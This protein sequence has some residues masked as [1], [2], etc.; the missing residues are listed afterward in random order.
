[1]RN[2]ELVRYN[3]K[4]DTLFN[5]TQEVSEDFEVQSHWARYL[6]V[7]VCGFLEIAVRTTYGEY[8]SNKAHRNVSNYVTRKLDLFRSPS[9]GNIIELTGLFS[10]E[11]A[12][13]LEQATDGQLKD[14][15]NS[16]VAVR[17]QIAHGKDASISYV[18]VREYYQ[19]AVKVVKLLE[20]QCN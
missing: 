8:A 11:W 19:S 12:D 1:M 20:K 9:M 16:I 14:A 5:K 6:C 15:V 18:R 7:L 13:D 4:L 2:I 3:Q 10:K 17:H